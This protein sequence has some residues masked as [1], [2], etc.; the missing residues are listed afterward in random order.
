MDYATH[1]QKRNGLTDEEIKTFEEFL[2]R[3]EPY[4]DDTPGFDDYDNTG[5]DFDRLLATDVK[6]ILDAYRKW[7]EPQ[8]TPTE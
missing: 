8:N 7:K 3:H 1:F 4:P 2:A 6:H 5:L